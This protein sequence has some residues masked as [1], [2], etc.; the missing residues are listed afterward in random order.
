MTIHEQNHKYGVVK[1]AKIT[2]PLTN[3]EVQQAKPK[4]KYYTLL[5][6]ECLQLRVKINGTKSWLFNYY[7]PITK[8][9]KN[10]SLG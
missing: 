10:F 4:D 7:H 1:M 3:T 2:K 8:K 9:R 6:N 5:D